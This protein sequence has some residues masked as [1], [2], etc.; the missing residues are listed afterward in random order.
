MFSTSNPH[1]T[2]PRTTAPQPSS[3][4]TSLRSEWLG[5]T[6]A[7]VFC[8]RGISISSRI[9]RCRASFRCSC[10]AAARAARTPIV[11][12]SCGEP[13]SARSPFRS[14][15]S[16]PSGAS[17]RTLSRASVRYCPSRCWQ[18]T[19][20]ASRHC[21]W[22]SASD[23][24]SWI[25]SGVVH[26][27]SRPTPEALTSSSRRPNGENSSPLKSPISSASRARRLSAAWRSH[28]T[29]SLCHTISS[30]MFGSNT[31]VG[32]SLKGVSS[33][34]PRCTCA[35][36]RQC[37]LASCSISHTPT[38]SRRTATLRDRARCTR[39]SSKTSSQ[40]CLAAG[41]AM[42]PQQLW[43]APPPF[44]RRR[45]RP[46]R[47]RER[48]V[49]EATAFAVAADDHACLL[50]F[51]ASSEMRSK[52]GVAHSVWQPRDAHP[53]VAHCR[54]ARSGSTR[55]GCTVLATSLCAP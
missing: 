32:M 51:T 26:S 5:R 10:R 17:M 2:Q 36:A 41:V 44:P 18:I 21:E 19:S 25:S 27:P 14:W 8:G 20:R 33:R 3:T 6:S 49:S 45:R 28:T 4:R 29:S 40:P 30:P 16:K 43:M 11:R 7:L 31:H 15:P 22:S 13:I 53:H 12:Q 55:G 52:P 23:G 1:T 46:R 39:R 38:C 54:R 42:L 35:P 24:T 50:D 48:H 34:L 9:A 37:H 47:R